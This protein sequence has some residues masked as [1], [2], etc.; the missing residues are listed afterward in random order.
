M[1]PKLLDFSFLNTAFRIRIRIG[2]EVFGPP[3]SDLLVRSAD[4]DPSII[5]Q[6]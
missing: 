2:S 6:K 4:P 3:G 5:K 1:V